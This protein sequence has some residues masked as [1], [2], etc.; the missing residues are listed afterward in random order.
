MRLFGGAPRARFCDEVD[1]LDFDLDVLEEMLGQDDLP[2]A[3]LASLYAALRAR[4]ARLTEAVELAEARQDAMIYAEHI[5][6][7]RLGDA[8]APSAIVEALDA[9]RRL[10]VEHVPVGDPLTAD[11][12]VFT[13]LVRSHIREIDEALEALAA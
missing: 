9:L 13:A 12:P 4:R 3:T 11:V 6:P 10:E 5:A 2:A 1:R 7:A 8:A